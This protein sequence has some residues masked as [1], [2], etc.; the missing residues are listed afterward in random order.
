MPGLV[1]E[2]ELGVAGDAG[3]EIG[4][5]RDGFIERIGVQRLGVTQRCGHGLDAG[6]RDV[7]ER[8][9]FG[10]RPA[11]GLRVGAQGHGLGFDLGL[12]C[13]MI[14]AHSRRAARI[15]ATSMK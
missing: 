12:N 5:Q 4:G 10:E 14:F 13:L 1:L 8:V 3:R 7:V 2:E 15:L 9:L 6:A 11:R